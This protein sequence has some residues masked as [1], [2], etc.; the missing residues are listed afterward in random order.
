MCQ[1][2]NAC[3]DH[4]LGDEKMSCPPIVK[5]VQLFIGIFGMIII[6]FATRH[7][8]TDW[9]SQTGTKR[10]EPLPENMRGKRF[11]IE[12]LKAEFLEI[13]SRRTIPTRKYIG[14]RNAQTH[15]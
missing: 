9:R 5:I 10:D 3:D 8:E 11:G 12:E 7:P 6:E 2:N 1:H 13:A 4:F 14:E 15:S